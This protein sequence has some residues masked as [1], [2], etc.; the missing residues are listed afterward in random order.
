MLFDE[1][2]VVVIVPFF[3]NEIQLA[4]CKAALKN[5]QYRV[6]NP[7]FEIDIVDDSVTGLGFT[8]TVN[9]GL[10]KALSIGY[11]YAIILNQDCYLAVNA[12]EQMV[13]FMEAH[14]KC[15]I[16][17]IKQRLSTNPDKIIHGG[18]LQCFPAGIHE[19]G[20]V[21]KGDCNTSKQVQW[22]NGAAMIVNMEHLPFFGFMDDNMKM[23]GSDSDWSFT[24]RARGFEV[25]YIAEAECLHE[26]GI[27]KVETADMQRQIKLDMS[28]FR[29]KW[30]SGEVFK[31]L[32]LEVF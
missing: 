28:Y 22:A 2:K 7:A 16:A 24:A 10:V 21:S 29:D 4:S 19:G 9:K 32:S 27:S 15:A 17:G 26:Q 13:K 5:N 14:P 20:F 18:T 6:E 23:F 31:D 11:K 1:T 30:L 25:W 12:V 3:K 8:K